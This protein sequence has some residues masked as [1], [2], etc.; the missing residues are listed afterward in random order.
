LKYRSWPESSRR[1]PLEIRMGHAIES[2]ILLGV[3][4]AGHRLSSIHRLEV[5]G[6]DAEPDGR[7]RWPVK[8]LRCENR[9]AGGRTRP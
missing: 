4:A 9:V 5:V 1:N 2:W 7:P 3:Q 8:R 6:D